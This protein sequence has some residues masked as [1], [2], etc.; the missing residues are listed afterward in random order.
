MADSTVVKVFGYQY[1]KEEPFPIV[2]YNV[3]KVDHQD[4]DN[5]AVTDQEIVYVGFVDDCDPKLLLLLTWS[6]SAKR[7][8]FKMLQITKK[9][10]L[11]S[12]T[13]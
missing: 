12:Y 3:N 8:F 4:S 5:E 11:L 10:H 1:E 9:S 7:T 2:N 6:E 13:F